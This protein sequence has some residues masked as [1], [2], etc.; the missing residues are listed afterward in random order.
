MYTILENDENYLGIKLS[1]KVNKSEY[2]EIL[3]LF[4]QKLESF[5]EID[6]LVGFSDCEKISLGALWEDLK[7]DFNNFRTI[8]R[9]AIVGHAKEH[10]FLD[11]ISEPFVSDEAKLFPKEEMGKARDWAQSKTTD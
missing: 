11:P 9:F 7:F 5:E 2:K 10:K 6:L 1:E 8:R 3:S 4:T